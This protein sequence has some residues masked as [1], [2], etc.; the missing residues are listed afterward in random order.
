MVNVEGPG[1]T[2]RAYERERKKVKAKAIDSN[3]TTLDEKVAEQEVTP[4]SG[5]PRV[6][7]HP[8]MAP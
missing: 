4:L 2:C 6:V 8:E 7:F 5:C 1:C 3:T